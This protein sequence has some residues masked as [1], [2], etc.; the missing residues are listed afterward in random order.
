[1]LLDPWESNGS[2]IIPMQH[3]S[4]V[5][6]NQKKVVRAYTSLGNNNMCSDTRQRCSDHAEAD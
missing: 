4:G 3:L 5:A 2:R 1:M 6:L